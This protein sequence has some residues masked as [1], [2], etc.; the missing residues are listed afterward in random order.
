MSAK[1]TVSKLLSLA[2]ITIGGD[3]PG[4]IRVHNDAFYSRILRQGS[5]GLGESYM[6]GWWDADDLDVFFEK[7]FKAKLHKKVIGNVRILASM[8][9]HYI[10][11]FQRKSKAYEVGEEHYDKGNDLYKV[12]LDK[13][14]AYTCAYWKGVTTLD[15]AQEQKL[16]LVCK[17]AKLKPGMKVLDI[18]G[19][20]GSFAKFAVEN[21]GVE[22]VATTISKEQAALGRELTAGMPID[23]RLEDYR[24]TTGTYDAIV[25]I[26]MFEHVGP[27]N[28]DVYMKKAYS[29]LSDSGLFVLHTIGSLNSS[30]VGDPWIDKYIFPNGVLPSVAQIGKSIEK[31]FVMEDWHN[32]GSYYADTLMAW[33]ENFDKGWESLKASYSERFYRMWS[34][35]LHACAGG[36]RSR[37]LQLWQIVL[38]KNGV[39]GVYERPVLGE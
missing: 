1:D 22:V 20:W 31:K 32:F 4:D 6:D 15:E 29:L 3:N 24:E 27:K 9:M 18:G 25:S 16:D 26:G 19:G 10:F 37:K 7:V 21:Y 2:D 35:Y 5:L 8:G 34:Y 12:M 39:E 36:F 33:F 30:M 14:M 13:R 28:Y 23:I 38:S 17:K 11:N